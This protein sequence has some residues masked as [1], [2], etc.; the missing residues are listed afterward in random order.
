VIEH[1]DDPAL[2]SRWCARE[3]AAGRSIG[4]VPTMGALHAG[5]LSLVRRALQ[6][7]Q[8][9]V[10]S[11]FVN[12]LQFDDPRDLERYPRDLEGDF[13]KLG[14]EGC[15]LVFTG[16]LE[17]FFPGELDGQGR[18]PRE[19]LLDP[20]PAARG[21]EGA[22][23][24]GHFAGVATIVDRLFELVGPAR[25]YFGRK[26]YQ[27][28]LVVAGLAPRHGTEVVICPTV[29]APDGLA[30]SS[31]NQLLPP[32]SRDAALSLSRGLRAAQQAW[33]AG[34]R[35]SEA[36]TAALR[37]PLARAL[38]EV[39]YAEL[40]DPERFGEGPPRGRLSRA[41]ALVAARVAGVRLID[42]AP[43]D[44][45]LEPGGGECGA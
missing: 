30:L 43:L 42:N 24:P 3:R 44:A 6:E 28:C 12:P 17:G 10:A 41:V 15:H 8:R 29:R 32:G 19:R 25:A 5:H 31:R 33:A 40:R 34:E 1:L 23:R 7:N 18:L 22:F 36:L 16:T 26:D 38:V 11:I 35:E 9:V 45:A 27:Q 4:F 39:E 2:A 13:A 37:A 20:G 14:G 21:L